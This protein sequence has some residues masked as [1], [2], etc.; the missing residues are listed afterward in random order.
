MSA[1]TAQLLEQFERLSAEEQREFSS[2]ILQ[3]TSQLDYGD[4]S[5]DELT[6]SA[7]RMFALLDEEEDAASR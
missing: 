4:I 1:A 2:V 5:D 3:R 7:R 6:A